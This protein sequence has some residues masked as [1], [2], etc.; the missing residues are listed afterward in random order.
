[1]N[2]ER[3]I[4]RLRKALEP[5]GQSK[6]DW[7]IIC[8]LAK[9]MGHG[10]S[11]NYESAEDIWNEIR[12]V[13]PAGKGITYS[14]LD[15]SGLQWPCPTEEHP[16]TRLLHAESFAL[17]VKTALRRVSY[18]PTSEAT[19]QQFPFLLTTGRSLY[20]FNAGTMT[21]RTR[22]VEL[23][24]TDL[25]EISTEDAERMALTDGEK[26]RVRSRYGEAV[27][28]VSITSALAAGELFATFQTA[29][30]FLNRVTSAYRDR[31]V[32]TPEYKVTAVDVTKHAK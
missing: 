18:L 20:Q 7:E 6:P 4:Q 16:G 10:E 25:L 26:V 3:R 28:P 5:R 21:M 19:D 9:A 13:W 8:K 29:E 15:D 12:S 17:G 2:S 23:R 24:P 32:K 30:A 22:N 1:M 11:F 14:R 31:Y 27:L